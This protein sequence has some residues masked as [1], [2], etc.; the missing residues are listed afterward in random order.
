VIRIAFPHLS[1]GPQTERIISRTWEMP[2]DCLGRTRKDRGAASGGNSCG[3]ADDRMGQEVSR[4][5]RRLHGGFP[6]HFACQCV[7][8]SEKCGQDHGGA[9]FGDLRYSW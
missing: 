5:R 6:L 9:V 7:I 1:L 8:G 2:R 3:P 4:Q